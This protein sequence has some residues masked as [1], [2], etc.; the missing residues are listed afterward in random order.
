MRRHILRA[1]RLARLPL[2]VVFLPLILLSLM[3]MDRYSSALDLLVRYPVDLMYGVIES[4]YFFM[5]KHGPFFEWVHHH[6][7]NWKFAWGVFIVLAALASLV[8]WFWRPSWR[9][10]IAL[11]VSL[12]FIGSPLSVLVFHGV[13]GHIVSTFFGG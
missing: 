2:A 4:W 10:G 5:V 6:S 12:L 11:T 9:S 13:V 7:L 8:W 1:L 3:S